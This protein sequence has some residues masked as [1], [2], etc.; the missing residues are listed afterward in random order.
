MQLG[1]KYWIM[2]SHKTQIYVHL[3]EVYILVHHSTHLHFLVQFY[4]HWRISS[5]LLL[6]FVSEENE[7]QN[8]I[9]ASI[10]IFYWIQRVVN[11][12]IILLPS[13]LVIHVN[14]IMLMLVRVLVVTSAGNSMIGLLCLGCSESII[15]NVL[16]WS[17][18]WLIVKIWTNL[19]ASRELSW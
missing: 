10:S 4:R 15:V 2:T 11:I 19:T 16:I 1:F 7:I 13:K 3:A 9:F 8:N 12:V 17:F 18:T 14:I 6:K 5:I